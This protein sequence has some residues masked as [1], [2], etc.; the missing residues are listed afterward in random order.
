MSGKR[1]Q[2]IC[3]F[4]N[5]HI[6]GGGITRLKQ[7]LAGILRDVGHCSKVPSDVQWKMK[8]LLDDLKKEQ[9]KKKV[10][11]EIGNPYSDYVLSD[12]DEDINVRSPPSIRSERAKGK[13]SLGSNE[14]KKKSTSKLLCSK[15]DLWCST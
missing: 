6:Q 2:T 4:Y 10:R 14:S 15:N 11:D 12:E 13:E 5:K 7:H 3:F 1:N 8:Q 9:A